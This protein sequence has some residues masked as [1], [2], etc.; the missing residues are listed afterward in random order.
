LVH[1]ATKTASVHG[2][3]ETAY[4]RGSVKLATVVG[5]HTSS[6]VRAILLKTKECV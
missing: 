6:V 1:G 3:H 2:A 4:V 5:D